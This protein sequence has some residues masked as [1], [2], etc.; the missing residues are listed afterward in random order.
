MEQK[1]YINSVNQMICTRYG[2]IDRGTEKVIE[3]LW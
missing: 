3:I 2:A 1:N